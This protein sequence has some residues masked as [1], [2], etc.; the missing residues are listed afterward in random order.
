MTPRERI[1]AL[2]RPASQAA[3]AL[4]LLIVGLGALLALAFL[5][6]G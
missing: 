6:R 2:P 4:V 1:P 5:F 3:A